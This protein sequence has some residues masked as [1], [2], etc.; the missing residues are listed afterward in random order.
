M[1]KSTVAPLSGTGGVTTYYPSGSYE[2]KDGV[3][4]KYYGD[5]VTRARQGMRV[6]DKVY[7][8]L[9]DHIGSTSITV[10]DQGTKIAEKRYLPWGEVRVSIFAL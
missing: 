4:T 6:D 7:Y 5:G 9:S 3:V 10:D 1:V 2:E 8:T